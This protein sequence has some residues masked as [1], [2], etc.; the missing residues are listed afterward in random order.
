MK[1]YYKPRGCDTTMLCT[2][3]TSSHVILKW[4]A[5]HSVFL[6]HFVCAD[7]RRVF[8]RVQ[9]FQVSFDSDSESAEFSDRT[10]SRVSVCLVWC[11]WPVMMDDL[12]S[13]VDSDK[14]GIPSKCPRLII[15]D[16]DQTFTQITDKIDVDRSNDH[17]H[18]VHY[19]H[20]NEITDLRHESLN[21]LLKSNIELM[22][23]ENIELKPIAGRSKI[24]Y[25]NH[26][27]GI[28]CG[29]ATENCRHEHS[30]SDCNNNNG[31]MGIASMPEN[32]PSDC[33]VS[34]CHRN[35]NMRQHHMHPGGDGDG[36][37]DNAM[38]IGS[39]GSGGG[40]ENAPQYGR[41][42]DDES[43]HCIPIDDKVVSSR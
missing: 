35:E 33:D 42:L 3:H 9:L 1:R 41:L 13:S 26:N 24:V 23:N 34:L 15:D 29:C 2:P 38:L 40:G 6:W 11:S 32:R 5:S 21:Q 19:P 18:M 17:Y 36:G 8:I 4:Y 27:R 7:D 12:E 25:G 16:D 10:A 20:M 43:K 22:K 28:H 30:A 39:D 37:S 31:S 14:S